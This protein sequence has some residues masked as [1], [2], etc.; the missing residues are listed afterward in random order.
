MQREVL[1][2]KRAG[3]EAGAKVEVARLQVAREAIAA[4]KAFLDVL[5]SH[6]ELAATRVEWEG[7][8]KV[9]EDAVKQAEAELNVA[10]ENNKPRLAELEQSKAALDR[11]L[12]L[13]DEVMREAGSSDLSAETKAAHRRYLLDLSDRIVKLRA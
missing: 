6:N 11:L 4:T 8:V 9:A 1:R 5:R 13:F 7:R 2:T 10:A 3:I 12:T